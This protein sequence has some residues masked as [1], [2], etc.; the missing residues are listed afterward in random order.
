VIGL[1]GKLLNASDE[2]SPEAIASDTFKAVV[3]G[4]LAEGRDVCKSRVEFCS[5]AQNLFAANQLPSFKSG[6]DRGV[7]RRLLLIPF[8]RS[9]PL[10]ERIEDTAVWSGPSCGTR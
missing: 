2:L 8:T 6:V 5:V 1:M 7:Q 4:D 10:E 3:T 9:I